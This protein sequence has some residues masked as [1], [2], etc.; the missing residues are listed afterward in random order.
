TARYGDVKLGKGG[1]LCFGPACHPNLNARIELV[2]D[3]ADIPLQRE[4]SGRTTGTN[5][6][7]IFRSRSGVPATNLSLPLRYMHSPVETADMDDVKN[8][9]ELL[10]AFIAALDVKD[11]FRHKL[12]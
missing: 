8:I 6:D 1:C 5:T 10:T 9:I 4:T 7:Q 3:K 2:A 12:A 11:D